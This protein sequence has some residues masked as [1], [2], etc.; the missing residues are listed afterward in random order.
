MLWLKNEFLRLQDSNT[1]NIPAEISCYHRSV[2]C[3]RSLIDRGSYIVGFY[4]LAVLI[5]DI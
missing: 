3:D 2:H 4:F 5:D 1:H